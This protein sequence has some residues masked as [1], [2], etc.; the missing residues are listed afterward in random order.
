MAK[1]RKTREELCTMLMEKVR[2]H[3][4]CSHVVDVAITRSPEHNWGAAWTVV[5]HHPVCPAAYHI[6]KELQALYD[7]DE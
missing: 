7:L 2:E 5:G 3:N 4:A 6:E 1:E